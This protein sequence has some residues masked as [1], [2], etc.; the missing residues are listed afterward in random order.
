MDSA[1]KSTK[2]V[3]RRRTFGGG[4]T[5]I[6]LAVG[7]VIL[8]RGAETRIVGGGEARTFGGGETVILLAVGR[9]IPLAVQRPELLAVERPALLAVERQSYFS[10]WSTSVRSAEGVKP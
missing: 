8:L 7:R 2:P 4:E 5:V 10:A 3:T 1:R 6:L 9:V